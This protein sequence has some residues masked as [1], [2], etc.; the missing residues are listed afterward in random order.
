MGTAGVTFDRLIDFFVGTKMFVDGC[1]RDEIIMRKRHVRGLKV[2]AVP[3]RQ[4]FD[5][6]EFRGVNERH[7]RN[8]IVGLRGALS[9]RELWNPTSGKIGQTWGTC[10]WIR[11]PDCENWN[12]KF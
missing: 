2:T 6:G 4:A 1:S 10:H 12:E 3:A 9:A 8:V 11:K 5:N 7:N